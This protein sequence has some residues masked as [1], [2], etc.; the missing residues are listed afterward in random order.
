MKEVAPRQ[1]RRRN[2]S[3][4]KPTIV[5][6]LGESHELVLRSGWSGPDTTGSWRMGAWCG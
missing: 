2:I 6:N 4:Q 1:E 5:L 3:Q